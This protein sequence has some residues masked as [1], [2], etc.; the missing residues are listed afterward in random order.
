MFVTRP[1][2][3]TRYN[4]L[5]HDQEVYVRSMTRSVVASFA[6]AL[7]VAG[8]AQGEDK[9]FTIDDPP[10][11]V[12]GNVVSLQATVEGIE[13]VKADGDTSGNSGHFHVFI[14]RDPV[15]VGE[16]IPKEPGVV[17]SA[18]NP[19]KIY[20]LSEGEHTLTVV[21]GDGTHKRFGENLEQEITVDVE[22]PSVDG[23]APATIEEGDDVTVGMK[24]EGVKIVKADGKRSKETGHLHVL[25]DPENAPEAGDAIG[26]PVDNKIIH[27]TEKSVV[28]SGLK[29]GEHTLW[30][31]LGDGQH[32]AFDPPVMDK[33][34]VTVE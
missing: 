22:G 12:E 5:G 26:T 30:V 31:V 18:E 27:T 8:C 17:H 23:S 29:K 19:I 24:W 15:D 34:T 7:I 25:V 20:G 9:S 32:Y 3:L 14:D 6:L 28:V 13:I 11:S 21:M 33:L 2:R 10:S 4:E 16:V 1:E